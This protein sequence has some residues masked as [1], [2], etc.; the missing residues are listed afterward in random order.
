[1]NTP[2]AK[3]DHATGINTHTRAKSIN[4]ITTVPPP[5]TAALG[6]LRALTPSAVASAV[7]SS[8][9]AKT[10]PPPRSDGA[11]TEPTRSPAPPPTPPAAGG[12][13]LCSPSSPLL[14]GLVQAE[15]KKKELAPELKPRPVVKCVVCLVGGDKAWWGATK[16]N[17]SLPPK[18]PPPQKKA[19]TMFIMFRRFHSTPPPCTS[20]EFPAVIPA[21]N[22]TL[23]VIC[24]ELPPEGLTVEPTPPRHFIC[25][26]GGNGC[27]GGHVRHRGE[28][29][30]AVPR[31]VVTAAA[32]EAAGNIRRVN[33]L[34]GLVHCPVPGCNSTH[35]S[36]FHVAR[37][38]E[39]P[40][41]ESY[42]EGRWLL[43]VAR[44][45]AAVGLHSC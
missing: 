28:S 7:G 8:D 30:R 2:R 36:D 9:T 16:E 26:D 37:H 1:V 4:M 15:K 6:Q 24:G 25:G 32:E 31:L 19:L 45:E 42:L 44:A 27:L 3:N 22:S 35:Y 33:E 21:E 39:E 20:K 34:E 38:C 13:S 14:D 18:N 17:A 5:R 40:E 41:V 29:L 23:G 43:A 10:Y 11:S 12:P